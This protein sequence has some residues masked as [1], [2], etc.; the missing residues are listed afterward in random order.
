[1]TKVALLIGVSKYHSDLNPLPAAI[2]DVE[3][4]KQVLKDPKIG[5][6]DK[7]QDLINPDLQEMQH[8]V[9]M[10][11]TI[12]RQRDDLLVLYFSGHGIKDDTN[13]LYLST[14]ITSKNNKGE[15]LRSTAVPAQFIHE[16]MNNSRARRQVVILDCCFSGAFD[17]SLQ[18]KD[19]GSFDLHR[20]LGAEGRVVL[21][22]SSSTQYSFEQK[23]TGISTYT[24]YIVEGIQ[25]GEGDQDGDGKIS[26]L[27]LHEYANKK[28]Q[29]ELPTVTPKIIVLR[30]KGFEIILAKAN[31]KVSDT[32]KEKRRGI[33]FRK[34]KLETGKQSDSLS[35]YSPVPSLLESIQPFTERLLEQFRSYYLSQSQ[36][37]D[38]FSIDMDY[39][40]DFIRL[41]SGADFVFTINGDPLQENWKL[42]SQ[43]NLREEID[44]SEYAETVKTRIL[45]NIKIESVFTAGW[46]G[47]YRVLYD[48]KDSVSKVF[49]LI[50]L[51]ATNAAEIMIVCGLSKESCFLNDAFVKVVSSFYKTTRDGCLTPSRV[52]A[53]VLDELKS[54]Y[55]FLPFSSYERRFELFCEQLS[56]VV[57]YFEPI[58]DLR[59]I[60]IVGWEA[61]ARDPKTLLAPT[62]LFAAAELW[63]RKFIIQLDIFL[64]RLAAS[65][66]REA[67]AKA[68]KNR[69][70]E[71]SPLSV[72]VY[73]ESLMRT[74][75]FEA[76]RE[77]TT[78]NKNGY[79]LLQPDSLVLEISEKAG[80]PTYDN[81][82]RLHSPL[83]TFKE[84]LMKYAQDLEIKFGID[85]FGV[86][87]ASVSR[88]AGLKPPYVKID[89]DILHKHQFATILKFVRDIVLESSELHITKV[90][91]EGLDEHSPVNL[92][93][94]NSL[95]IRYVQGYVVGKAGPDVYRLSSE[96]YK[97]LKRLLFDGPS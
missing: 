4:I 11:F 89:R 72:N 62:D 78:P 37:S 6:F 15:L 67:C 29:Q 39:I 17:P 56:Q 64:L 75:Y 81:G 71:I 21:A 95:G 7:V 24:R 41:A 50:P 34:F 57:I 10:L 87:H 47:I 70:D 61:L 52:E 46:N 45:S 25:T 14:R 96:K 40:L 8:A 19:D 63:G 68:K 88:L 65:S 93:Q 94:L 97:S 36:N 22:S 33:G 44:E 1:M 90:I 85:D 43:S 28:V 3:A 51:D 82:V 48:D 27:E 49:V 77:L 54:D 42:T 76:V 26:V 12:D 60:T 83:A 66:Y 91:V 13:R 38:S 58:L 59:K 69:P 80:L 53:F 84:R 9:E 18:A 73:P 20:E 55:G 86:G 74:S 92:N 23:E 35:C 30:D 32:I 79:V 16:V 5:G 2:K 31:K